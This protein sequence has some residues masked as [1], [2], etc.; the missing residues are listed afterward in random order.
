VEAGRDSL[1]LYGKL[2]AKTLD[3]QRLF[4]AFARRQSTSEAGR[5]GDFPWDL[6]VSGRV[7]VSVDDRG[8]ANDFVT[9]RAA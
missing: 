1:A 6:P 3:P 2:T 5:P 8:R 7:A 9:S 4:D